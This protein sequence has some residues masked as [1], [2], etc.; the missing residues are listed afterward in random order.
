L[1][2][3]A[4]ALIRLMC[5]RHAEGAAVLWSCSSGR[6]GRHNNKR[7][8][9]GLFSF[10]KKK[11]EPPASAPDTRLRVGEPSRLE[12]EAERERQ[13]EIARATAAKIDEIE[14]AMTSDIF[15]EEPAW[16]S[17]PR[18]AP[19]AASAGHTLPMLELSTTELLADEELPDA[20]AAPASPPVVE[21][22]AILYANGQLEA[23]EQMLL[24]SLAEL[25]REE[26]QPWWMLF[27]LYQA[28]GREQQFES[29][30]IDYASHF[31]TSPPAWTPV[32]PVRAAQP[33]AGVAPAEA[34]AGVLDEQVGQQLQRLLQA[35]AGSPLVRL[36]FG[37]VRG[38][39]AGGCASLLAG[40]QALRGAGRQLV[41]AGADTLVA[42]LRP[43]L[44]IGERGAPQAPWLLLLE[45]LQLLNREKDFEETAMD[46][47]VTFE[48][49]PP[50]FEAPAHVA[51]AVASAAAAGEPSAVQRFVLPAVV[52]GDC[53]SLLD[54]VGVY[55]AQYDPVVL[56]CSRLARID[57]AA[58]SALQGAL[59][60]LAAGGRRIELRDLSH[61]VAALFKLLGFGDSARLFAHKY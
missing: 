27:D 34:F 38:A 6:G 19:A 55:A 33:V 60:E 61:L 37:A 51:T 30:A 50:S 43:M 49:S 5:A 52:G 32:M 15:A 53:A 35:D 23:A 2:L 57:Y 25:G 4:R 20:A 10:L 56:D 44:A 29:I 41:L 46:Y 18:R 24:A 7:E 22:S 58:A 28:S 8:T 26:R 3:A 17:V 54:A 12:T 39:T 36:E 21:E 13:R 16:G 1:T 42:V 40:L 59:R 11:N 48:V 45:L 9:M 14:L 31:E 47:C